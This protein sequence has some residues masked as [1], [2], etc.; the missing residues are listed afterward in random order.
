MVQDK[1]KANPLTFVLVTILIDAIGFG[2]IIPVMPALLSELLGIPSEAAARWGGYLTFFYAAMHFVFGPLIGNLSDRFGRRPVLLA[3]LGALA[4][5]YVVMGCSTTIWILFV[6]RILTGICGATFPT[7]SAYVADVTTVEK[8]AQA[9]GMI[10]AAFG[11]GFILGPAIGGLLGV[12]NSRTPFFAAAVLAL[13]NMAYGYFVLPESLAVNNRRK[14]EWGR[15]NPLGAFRRF[16]RFPEIR[17][18]ILTLMFF[19]FAHMV[20]PS[21]WNFHADG[22]YGWGSGQIGL[23]LMTF[24][25]CSAVVQAVL[26]RHFIKRFGERQ[27]AIF[28]LVINFVSFIGFAFASNG[29]L[30]YLWIPIAALGAITGPSIQSIM[31]SRINPQSQG[32]LQGAN[33][34]V[35]AIANM[36]SPIIMTQVYSFFSRPQAPLRFYGSA[37]LLAA[38]LTAIALVPLLI[39]TRNT[40]GGTVIQGEFYLLLHYSRSERLSPRWTSQLLTFQSPWK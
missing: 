19:S 10:G 24:G 6:G 18:L 9:F 2:L 37:F 40:S 14:F 27:T 30:L 20:Y 29:V 21:T 11:I 15:A 23:S 35:Q 1:L 28:G 7:V 22:R 32:E 36:L 5:D 16:A 33:A 13:V 12:F 31:T 3:S 25:I 26:I 17:W 4:F 8:R 34:S 38:M 39:G